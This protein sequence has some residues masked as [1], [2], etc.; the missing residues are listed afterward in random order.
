MTE[1]NPSEAPIPTGRIERRPD[2][3]TLVFERRFDFPAGHIWDVLTNGDK[4]AQW[5]GMLTPGWQLGKE[6]RL[7]M[8]NAE[9]TGTVLQMSPGLS[10][11]FTWEDPLGDESVLDWQVLET[12]DGS[13]LQFR[14]H[15]ESADFLTEGAA[16]WQGILDAFDDVASGREPARASMDQWQAL[17]DA[18]AREFNVSPTMGQMDAA[19]V[20]FERW[21]DAAAGDVG[22]ALDRAASEVGLGAEA[23]VEITD[24][25][26]GHARAVVRQP[27]NA[28]H[29][30]HGGPNE[31]P[32]L[33]AAW[34]VALDAAGDHLAGNPW[35]PSSRRLAALKEFY[36]SSAGNA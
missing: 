22:R 7:D 29:G 10:L 13:L 24:D 11:Q 21:Y 20:V 2:G 14:T 6:Y 32:A 9:V 19:G 5:L 28:E 3:Y 17:R 23:A 33:L 26:A 35:H 12:P 27:V 25:D 16:G 30:G 34:H 18:Y 8:G 15:E 1:S 36:A 31:A 4:V